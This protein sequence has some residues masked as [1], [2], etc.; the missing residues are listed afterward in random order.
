MSPYKCLPL[1]S[2]ICPIC[3]SGERD[4]ANIHTLL[5]QGTE[6]CAKEYQRVVS[7][8]TIRY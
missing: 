4:I 7:R 6:I 3:L 1:L 8:I 2:D 5:N